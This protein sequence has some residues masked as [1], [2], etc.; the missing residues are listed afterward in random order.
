MI[1]IKKPILSIF[2]SLLFI[3]AVLFFA[4]QTHYRQYTQM[5][6]SREAQTDLE[7]ILG[8]EPVHRNGLYH[9]FPEKK[10]EGV[11]R[12]GCFGDSFTF[13]AEVSAEHSYPSFLQKMLNSETDKTYE[14]INFSMP[15]YGFFQAYAL[16]EE[17]GI[18]YDLDFILLG[19]RGFDSARDITFNHRMRWTGDLSAARFVHSRFVLDGKGFKRIDPIGTTEREKVFNYLRF[20]P[21]GIYLRYD[22]YAPPF[23]NGFFKMLPFFKNR[24]LKNPFYYTRKGRDEELRILYSRMIARMSA[25]G[26]KVCLLHNNTRLIGRLMESVSPGQVIRFLPEKKKFPYR[27]LMKHNS[28]Y[29]NEQIAAQFFK[30]ITGVKYPLTDF[31]L[32]T[33][34]VGKRPELARHFESLTF[35]DMYIEAGG[36]RLSS[37]VE[38]NASQQK[39]EGRPALKKERS[40]LLVIGDLTRP[41]NSFF[42]SMPREVDMNSQIS[43]N[44]GP[45]FHDISDT[46]N[47]V[48]DNGRFAQ[49][50]VGR[51]LSGWDIKFSDEIEALVGAREDWFLMVDGYPVLYGKDHAMAVSTLH[52]PEGVELMRFLPI[53]GD[54]LDLRQLPGKGSLYLHIVSPE[55][56]TEYRLAAEEWINKPA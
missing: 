24:T 41:L 49:V 52:V 37:L 53:P 4:H 11:I 17:L 23:L 33:A 16:W 46:V 12:I 32:E 31:D 3:I 19:P 54:Y 27:A 9:D 1:K 38:H 18:K 48:D 13:G 56:K 51:C 21:H 29:G 30:E 36:S 44:T 7:K 10:D 50:D 20:I 26:A 14:V 25:S 8:I 15:G 39:M 45:Y 34:G 42:I 47:V 6:Y 35:Y 55:G 2:L 22:Y 43:I 5:P 40:G 28:S